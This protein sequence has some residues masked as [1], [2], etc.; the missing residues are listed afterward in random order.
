MYIYPDIRGGY[1]LGYIFAGSGAGELPLFR[2]TVSRGFFA[3][4]SDVHRLLG[5]EDVGAGSD[6]DL[7]CQE[8]STLIE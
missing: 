1:K 7:R 3:F 2:P 6:C 8:L 5:I 4:Q